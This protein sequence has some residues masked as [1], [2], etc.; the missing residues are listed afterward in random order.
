MSRLL[1]IPRPPAWFSPLWKKG[2][3]PQTPAERLPPSPKGGQGGFNDGGPGDGRPI[4]PIAPSIKREAG[5]LRGPDTISLRPTGAGWAYLALLLTLFLMAV[6]YSNNLIH[7]LVFLLFAFAMLGAW[8]ARRHL[9][10][11]DLRVGQAEPVFAGDLARL[12]LS[13]EADGRPG[14]FAGEAGDI[15]APLEGGQGSLPLACPRRGRRAVG[16]PRLSTRYPLG[17]FEASRVFESRGAVVVWPRPA[18]SDW[19]PERAR[20]AHQ[21]QEAEDFA[22]LRPYA[23]GDSPRRLAWKAVARGLPPQTKLFDGAEGEEALVL[24]W[25]DAEGDGEARLSQL[26]RWCL[27]AH[28]RELEYALKLPGQTPRPGRGEAHLRECLTVLA[29]HGKTEAAT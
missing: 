12:P 2:G 29:L 9:A 6:N 24:D 8:R 20:P 7:A 3:V 23:P 19:P 21:G 26:A 13:V 1:F 15:G 14:L 16:A 28:G 18:G 25:E 27:N 10:G 22:G 11:L 4:S 17:L 5:R